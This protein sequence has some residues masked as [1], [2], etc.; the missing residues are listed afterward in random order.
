MV[1]KYCVYALCKNVDALTYHGYNLLKCFSSIA[2][3]NG[4]FGELLSPKGLALSELDSEMLNFLCELLTAWMKLLSCYSGA[5]LTAQSRDRLLQMS[6]HII[7]RNKIIN[8]I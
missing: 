8:S 2:A 5:Q 3:L 6:E 4:K 7:N 1:W